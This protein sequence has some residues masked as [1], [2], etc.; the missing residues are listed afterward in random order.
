MNI[1]IINAPKIIKDSLRQLAKHI[2]F[3][4]EAS[5]GA[6][7]HLYFGL[8]TITGG[9]VAVKYYYW[10]G[11]P[12]YHAE[13]N[14][15]AAIN[16]DHI[17]KIHDASLL[18]NEYAYFITPFFEKGDLEDR[19]KRNKLGIKKAISY[20]INI[21][22]GL[23]D[24]HSKRFVHRD[25]KPQNIFINNHD[26]ALIGDFGSVKYLPESYNKVSGSGHSLLYTP[27]ESFMSKEY[28]FVGD[29]YQ[30][31]LVL[32]ELLGGYL[33]YNPIDWLNSKQLIELNKIDDQ[34]EKLLYCDQIIRNKIIK[35]KALDMDSLPAWVCNKLKTTIKKACS[36]DLEKRF[37]NPSSFIAYLHTLKPQ[38][39]DWDIVDN[40]PVFNGNKMYRIIYISKK[41]KHFVEKN[42]G[43]GW[44]KDN[45]FGEATL[46]ELVTAIEKFDFKK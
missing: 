29:T 3:E 36:L 38:L 24:L 20:T 26:Q 12:I 40:C 4:K 23:S 13:P 1:D 17:V 19:L 30:V 11:N 45:Y 28:S 31:G 42:I 5:K 39:P 33:P 14:Y 21:L 37:K 25:L 34:V 22:T 7:G 15:L 6:N 16:S 18:D 2:L 44:R 27:P 35:S 8:N 9:K 43:F 10:G 41:Q 46:N 32:Y